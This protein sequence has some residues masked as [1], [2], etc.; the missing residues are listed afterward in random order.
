MNTRVYTVYSA[1]GGL[2]WVAGVTIAGYFLGQIKF[3]A[4][5]VDLILIGAVVVVV[6]DLRRPGPAC[7]SSASAP[8][9]TETIS[10]SR[11]PTGPGPGLAWINSQAWRT[12]DF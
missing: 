4:D 9:A 7:T 5:N 8:S 6:L 11:V 1:I 3:I 2:I 12:D 10:P